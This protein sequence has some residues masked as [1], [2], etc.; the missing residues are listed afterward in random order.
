MARSTTRLHLP[1]A[2]AAAIAAGASAQESKPAPAD[3]K[4]PAVKPQPDAK[5]PPMVKPAQPAK[6]ASAA[7]SGQQVTPEGMKQL[8]P[9]EVKKMMG[10][11]MPTAA[12][13]KPMTPASPARTAHDPAVQGPQLVFEKGTL[14]LGKITDEKEITSV[15]KF[16]NTGTST[17]TIKNA[18][19]SCGCTVPSLSKLVYEPNEEG[20][21]TIIYNPHNRKGDVSST[22]TVTSDDPALPSQ[23][24]PLKA[25]VT[26]MVTMD[27]MMLPIGQ[28]DRGSASVKSVT[29]TSRIP[30]L[31]ITQATPASPRLVAT[32]AGVT[33]AVVDGANI[34]QTKIDVALAPDAAYGPFNEMVTVRTSDPARTLNFTVSG[35]VMGPIAASP[36]RLSFPGVLPSGDLN[37]SLTVQS[38][39]GEPFTI[40]G[41]Q[42]VAQG[43]H[44]PLFTF[45]PQPNG[46]KT[47]WTV[48]ITGKAPGM[49]TAIRGELIVNT[50]SA[51]MP[52]LRVAYFGFV[53]P[54]ASAPP[55]NLNQK[56]PAQ[57]DAWKNNPSSLSPGN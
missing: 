6:G 8:S 19:G 12:G 22:I 24:I 46:D 14:D 35:E 23:Q 29:V 40:T 32:I 28:I 56:Q 50:D 9:E 16:R 26:Q 53:R 18:A 13:G 31:Q 30:D 33:D 39:K 54:A 36:A 3:T 20:E 38:R 27:P 7:G 51:E 2:L 17:L 49:Q 37:T 44:A 43:S 55:P 47:S 11:Q 34:R 10:G 25:N 15:V 52:Q 57:D 45:N 5:T 41:V 4:A 48:G 42:E 1:L 21:L